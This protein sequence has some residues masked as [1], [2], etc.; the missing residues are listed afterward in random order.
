MTAASQRVQP[1]VLVETA[2]DL[3]DV[4]SGWKQHDL[5]RFIGGTEG[6]SQMAGEAFLEQPYGT[7]LPE[8]RR[9]FYN[10]GI[11]PDLARSGTGS[12]IGLLVRLLKQDDDAGTITRGS[13]IYRHLYTAFWHGHII[14]ENAN[15]DGAENI[16][17]GS[18]QWRAAGLASLLDQLP[19]REGRVKVSSG[20]TAVDPGFLPPFNF[21]AGGDRSGATITVNGSAV[22]VHDL[23]TTTSGNPWTAAQ[24]LAHI[25]AIASRPTPYSSS[26][27]LTGFAW[28]VDDP[29]NCLAYIVPRLN[30]HGLTLY[31][32]INALVSPHRGLIWWLSVSGTTATINV[33]STMATAI[34][35]PSYTLP[36][37]TQTTTLDQ[38]EGPFISDVRLVENQESMYDIVEIRGARPWVAVTVLYDGT[39]TSSLQKGWSSSLETGWGGNPNFSAYENVWRRFQILDTWNGQQY[40]NSIVGIRDTLTRATDATNGS[41]GYT[42]ARTFAGAAAAAAIPPYCLQIEPDLPVSVGFSTLRV[43]P[44]QRTVIVVGSASAWWDMSTQWSV[45]V[46]QNPLSIVIDDRDN[47][48][49]IQAFLAAGQKLLVTIG[50]RETQPLRISWQRDPTLIPR[51]L[52]RIKVIEDPDLEQWIALKGCVTGTSVD[53]TTLT[54]LSDDVSARDDIVPLRARMALARAWLTVPDYHLSWRNQ[55][56]LDISATKRAGTLVTSV[57]RGDR[58]VSPNVVIA[59]RRW[60]LVRRDEALTYDTSYDT[61]RILPE[62]NVTL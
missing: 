47:G 5:I 49:A 48:R 43:G 21:L 41:D 60:S 62:L 4:D 31:Q 34:T 16:V 3:P 24:V 10:V 1:L 27:A 14:E 52:P 40:N 42:G 23:I 2:R 18:A 12:L 8:Y 30:L 44:R 22:Y 46:Q 56:T 26:S 6:M 7:I 57:D 38:A 11:D 50:V 13:G 19:L 17:G 59:P 9:Q 55:G 36:A 15:P 35:V 54:T 51:S 61:T 39:G 28:A 45:T 53:G 37:S 33:R 29:D 32:G 25:L 20:S 58:T